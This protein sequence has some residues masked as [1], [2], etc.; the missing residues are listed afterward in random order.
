MISLDL[1]SALQWWAMLFIIGFIFLPLTSTL[2]SKFYDRGYIFSKIMGISFISYAIFILGTFHLVPFSQFNSICTLVLFLA[3]FLLLGKFNKNFTARIFSDTF[4]NKWKLFIFEELLFLVCLLFW[5]FIRAHQPDIHNIEKFMDFGFINSILRSNYFPPKDM[6]LANFTI[7]YYY[8]GHLVTAIL[9]K[10]SG[11]DSPIAYNLML[12]SI[13]SFVFTESFSIGFN[14]L[15]QIKKISLKKTLSGSLLTAFLV[16]LSGNLQTIY[17]LFIQYK[18]DNPMPFW[19]LVFSL[20]TFPNS[21]WYPS[22]TRFIYHTIHEFPSYALVLSDLHGHLLDTPFTLFTIAFLFC[23]FLTLKTK[24]IKVTLFPLGKNLLY[25]F[26]LSL[27]LAIMYM[28]NAWDGLIYLLLITVLIGIFSLRKRQLLNFLKP[29]LILGV[30]LFILTLPFNLFY[31]PPISGL[32]ILCP[33]QFLIGKSIGPLIF[34]SQCQ[35]SPFWQLLILYG[36]F[37]F[38]GTSFLVFIISKIKNK[39]QEFNLSDNFVLILLLFASFLILIPELVYFKDIFTTYPRAN[40]MF[41]IAYQVF[42]ILSLSSGYIIVRL[43]NEMKTFV[44]IN[45]IKKLFF[46]FYWFL[47]LLIFFLI[48]IYPIFAVNSYYNGLKTYSGL[49]GLDY[50][51]QLYPSDYKAILWINKNIQGQLT[52]LE[53]QG[54]S[55]TDYERISVNTGLPTVI[56]W[57]VHEWFWRN[58]YGIVATRINDVRTI[59]ETDNLSLT[60][61]L[62]NKYHVSYIFI[63]TLERQKYIGLKEEKFKML[64][65]VIFE[66]KGTRFY[67]INF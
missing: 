17:S 53:A 12:A 40:T 20:Q 52:V 26:I 33:P 23:L 4:K 44:R 29:M 55:Y 19:Q 28:T 57:T 50:L 35:H 47:A 30:L 65:K 62:I 22:A 13:F 61:S 25:L 5:S 54:D 34:E 43:F 14:L 56:G 10:I 64:G 42:I 60:K 37:Y 41:K 49:N 9:T 63:G 21:Y 32:G 16:T 45:I 24:D 3:L 59:Y 15:Q 11:I 2:F 7:N 18:G 67:K 1:I 6:W 36:F 46:S 8:F 51:R 27:L 31:K 58:D 39:K 66:D 48:S 38:W